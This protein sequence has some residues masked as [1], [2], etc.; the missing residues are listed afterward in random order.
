MPE[1][2][3][4]FILDL[5]RTEGARVLEEK[6]FLYPY[7]NKAKE[8]LM[9]FLQIESNDEEQNEFFATN[10]FINGKRGTG[11][12]SI[13]LTLKRDLGKDDRFLV[14][15]I[16]DLSTNVQSVLLYLFAYIKENF[17]DLLAGQSCC[18]EKLDEIFYKLEINFPVFLKCFCENSCKYLCETNIEEILDKNELDYL[19]LL[20]NFLTSFLHILN[21]KRLVIL[22]DDFDLVVDEKTLIKIVIEL[23]VFLNQQEVIIIGAGDLENLQRRLFHFFKKDLDDDKAQELAKSYIEKLFAFR[24]V[25]NINPIDIFSFK[26]SVRIKYENNEKAV[27]LDAFLKRHESIK[28]LLPK[29]EEVVYYILDGLPIRQLVQFLKALDEKAR[30]LEKSNETLLSDYL[31]SSI[32]VLLVL[33]SAPFAGLLKTDFSIRIK[34]DSKGKLK[35]EDISPIEIWNAFKSFND[36][37]KE[38]FNDEHFKN[39]FIWKTIEDFKNSRHRFISYLKGSNKRIYSLVYMWLFE[40]F[41][42]L[43]R[44]FYPLLGITLSFLYGLPNVIARLKLSKDRAGQSKTKK[45]QYEETIRLLTFE[46]YIEIAEFS[47]YKDFDDSL[48]YLLVNYNGDVR[49]E[50]KDKSRYVLFGKIREGVKP[51]R[52]LRFY[53]YKLLHNT[54]VAQLINNEFKDEKGLPDL[55]IYD[56]YSYEEIDKEP[57]YG[58]KN[59]KKLFFIKLKF[60]KE[61]YYTK[62]T[63]NDFELDPETF[64]KRVN[65]LIKRAIHIAFRESVQNSLYK[66]IFSVYFP[67]LLIL[68]ALT[69]YKDAWSTILFRKELYTGK[70][71]TETDTSTGASNS[72]IERQKEIEDELRKILEELDGIAKEFFEVLIKD[73]PDKEWR[74]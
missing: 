66:N 33:D 15:P 64:D 21:K 55:L 32:L 2:K 74:K 70:K 46:D 18:S 69:D 68:A 61:F 37:L 5:T 49:H 36:F 72:Q 13:I 22:I 4:V 63:D 20:K 52:D 16:I 17:Y 34:K 35:V 19:N 8:K 54:Y 27:S 29:H 60:L 12:T 3:N 9:E 45:P 30:L 56:V 71:K 47:D 40:M 67:F 26:E 14:L 23:A 48:N 11:K 38:L 44:G 28:R 10:L 39:V 41:L 59:W 50:G 51:Y 31:I 25:I 73:I 62:L 7:V 42:F 1:D 53:I 57:D 58:E 65:N 6:F 24:N 43:G